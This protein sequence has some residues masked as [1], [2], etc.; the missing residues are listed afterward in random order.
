MMILRFEFSTS[1]TQVYY[2]KAKTNYLPKGLAEIFQ[3]NVTSRQHNYWSNS[4]R[5]LLRFD[6]EFDTPN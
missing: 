6:S 5:M 1:Q 4:E 3:N 2:F